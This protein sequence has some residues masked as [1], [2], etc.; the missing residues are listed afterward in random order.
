MG[1]P[2]PSGSLAP[3]VPPSIRKGHP[4]LPPERVPAVRSDGVG[5]RVV[6]GVLYPVAV[7]VLPR[8]TQALETAEPV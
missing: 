3:A 1:S 2:G 7:E 8:V 6:H 4:E 5:R